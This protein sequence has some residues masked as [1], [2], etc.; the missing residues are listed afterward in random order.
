MK[1]VNKPYMMPIFEK[2][3]EVELLGDGKDKSQFIVKTKRVK[4]GEYSLQ[5][6]INSFRDDC[7]IKKIV[8]NT[9]NLYGSLEN[10]PVSMKK[11]QCF[12]VSSIPC[13]VQ[14]RNNLEKSMVSKYNDLPKE[15]KAVKKADETVADFINRLTHE[16]IVDAIAQKLKLKAVNQEKK[17]EVNK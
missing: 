7:D 8:K 4:K 5:E 9:V 2:I 13:S 14:A 6:Y 17:E 15:I 12:D 10:S 1:Q 16:D 3:E 11:E